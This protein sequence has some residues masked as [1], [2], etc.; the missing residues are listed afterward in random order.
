MPSTFYGWRDGEFV[1]IGKSDFGDSVTPYVHDDSMPELKHLVSGE[2]FNSKSAY[3]ERNRELGL[4]VVGNDLLS[5]KPRNL[6]DKIDEKLVL[7]KIERAEAICSD[8]E[9]FRARQNE[10]I[11]RLERR[12]K[13]LGNRR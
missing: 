11:E 3:R 5:K 2:I 6:P 12:G 1:E 7:D 4:S 10:N 9:K 8:P 13:L